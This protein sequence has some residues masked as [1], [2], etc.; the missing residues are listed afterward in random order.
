MPISLHRARP[1]RVPAART[2][3]AIPAPAPNPTSKLPPNLLTT[4]QGLEDVYTGGR[5]EDRLALDVEVALT[6]KDEYGR[7]LTPKE[8]FRQLC[9]RCLGG[10]GRGLWLGLG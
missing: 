4:P 2:I 8:A 3:P 6:R 9:Y 5:Q 7:V 1:G 10:G